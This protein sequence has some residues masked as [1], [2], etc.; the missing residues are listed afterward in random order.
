MIL[1]HFAEMWF[2]APRGLIIIT[3][4][5]AQFFVWAYADFVLYKKQ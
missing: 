2:I 3:I 4:F 1:T 5:V